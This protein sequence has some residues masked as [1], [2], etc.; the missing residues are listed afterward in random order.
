ML[1]S[2]TT[3]PRAKLTDASSTTTTTIM[4]LLLAAGCQLGHLNGHLERHEK[5]EE[6]V[7]YVAQHNNQDIQYMNLHCLC[8][9]GS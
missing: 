9:A 5:A 4:S 8:T 6:S 1:L 2:S 7:L 3:L